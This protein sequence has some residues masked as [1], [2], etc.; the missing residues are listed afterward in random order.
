MARG[1]GHF[2]NGVMRA[3]TDSY[4]S[5][6]KAFARVLDAERDA[7]RQVSACRRRA[8]RDLQNTR[9][10]V[11]VLARQTQARLARLHASCMRRTSELVADMNRE[12]GAASSPAGTRAAEKALQVAAARDVAEWLWQRFVADGLKN[13]G[14]LERAHLYALLATDRDLAFLVDENDLA[15]VIT[16]DDVLLDPEV[17][18][19]VNDL[20]GRTMQLDSAFTDDRL[21]ANRRI[22]M[23]IN[24]IVGT[25]Y[26]FAQEGR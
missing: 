15:R 14:P 20:S 25:P 10:D 12:A 6:E 13:L 3:E 22:G 9:Q 11:R 19:L 8:D 1:A 17:I 26:I 5:V 21:D 18:T 4:R 23:A 7:L 16:T 2:E 24:F